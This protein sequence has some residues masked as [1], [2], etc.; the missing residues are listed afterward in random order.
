MTSKEHKAAMKIDASV[1]TKKIGDFVNKGEILGNFA[2]DAVKAPFDGTVEGTSFEPED[3]ALIV[4]LK[5]R[6]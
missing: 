4:V 3:H 2:G 5:K 6:G 1:F